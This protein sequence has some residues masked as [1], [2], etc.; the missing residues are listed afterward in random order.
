MIPLDVFHLLNYAVGLGA[1]K[2]LFA[3][4]TYAKLSLIGSGP[5]PTGVVL[6]R[7]EPVT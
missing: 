2:H 3:S 6:L 1:H 4:D 7:Y 5:C